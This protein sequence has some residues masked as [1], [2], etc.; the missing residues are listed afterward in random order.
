[1]ILGSTELPAAPPAAGRSATSARSGTA[2]SRPRRRHR[3][4]P[5]FSAVRTTQAAG[6]GCLLTVRHDAQAL[7]KASSTRSCAV[8]RSPTLTTTANRHSSLASR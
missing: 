8:S 1:M 6:T 4:I 7:A 3:E 5:V 2:T